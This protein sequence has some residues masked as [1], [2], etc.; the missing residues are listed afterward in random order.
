MNMHSSEITDLDNHGTGGRR[1]PIA[2]TLATF[3]GVAGDFFSSFNQL[4]HKPGHL[5]LLLLELVIHHAKY[6]R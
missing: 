2:I 6:T 1:E 4:N 5:G 3:S